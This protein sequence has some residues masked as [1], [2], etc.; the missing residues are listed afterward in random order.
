MTNIKSNLNLF[1]WQLDVIRGLKEHY[2]GY[3]H[4]VKSKRQCGKSTM[5]I[6]ILLRTAIENRATNSICLSPTL[7]QA[8]KI[9][10]S[11]K[12]VITPTKLYLKHNDIQM[13]IVLKNGSEINFK[14]AE[15]RVALK[16]YTVTGVWCIDE[17]AYINDEIFFDCLAW[18]NTTQAPIVICSTPDRKT[19][20]FYQYF[21]LGYENGNKIISYNWCD[22]DT[23]AL[24]S[25]E[26]L[27]EYRKQ[28]PKEKFKTDFL[29]EFLENEGGVFKDYGDV[30]ND[31]YEEGLNLYMG[32]DW[33]TGSNNDD[34][35]IC[36]FNSKQQMVDLY[37]FNDKDETETIKEIIRLIK[38]YK[39]LKVQVETNSIGT[40]FY[41]LLDK[42]IKAERLPVILLK[43]V[44]T[45]ESKERLINNFQVAIQ[46][47]EV[48]ILSDSMLDIEMSMYEMKLTNT[49]KKSYNAATGY[50][51]DCIIAMLLA[52]DCIKKGSYNIR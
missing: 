17:A 21:S 39:P 30:V 27:N 2:R 10:N 3:T 48:S 41:G 14:S 16:G 12:K 23:S 15:Q 4:V 43:F 18:T 24:L 51:D 40:V 25:D 36:I 28:I 7:A 49:G 20:F 46:N 22:Y 32:I 47:K 9:Y 35:A 1:Q 19:G 31:N 29:G 33:S 8:R 44:T 37:H 50:H 13:S 52:F 38:K 45:N 6:V 26:L 5:L 34:T 11:V 42:A